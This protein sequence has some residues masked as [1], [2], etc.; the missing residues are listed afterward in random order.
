MS[1]RENSSARYSRPPEK[2]LERAE[3]AERG[4]QLL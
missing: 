2:L 3:R 1:A 4:L